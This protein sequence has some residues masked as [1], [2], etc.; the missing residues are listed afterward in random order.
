[1][2]EVPIV[3]CVPDYGKQKKLYSETANLAAMYRM[4]Y[5]GLDKKVY[6]LDG[7]LSK[8]NTIEINDNGESVF[9]D[10]KFSIPKDNDFGRYI[11]F[12]S[13]WFLEKPCYESSSDNPCPSDP[14]TPPSDFAAV[15]A[16][17]T[18]TYRVASPEDGVVYHWNVTGGTADKTVGNKI[19]VQ[20]QDTEGEGVVAV[21]G[22]DPETHCASET[23][24]YNIKIHKLPSSAFD[25][26]IV[27]NGQPLNI[28][29]SGDAPFEILYTI[30]GEER[31]IKTSEPSYQLPNVAG[32]YLITKI[33]DASCEAVPTVN[34][35]AE[36]AQKM[37]ALRIVEE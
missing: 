25:N 10:T 9:T 33:I 19:S 18:K 5:Y 31:S 26:A 21:Y 4:M 1:L 29:S 3:D 15:C 28:L 2:I 13:S 22:E 6:I 37:K 7:P 24:T 36:I 23:V 27:C 34:N 17:Q 11:D 20:W 30:D 16:S 14:E 12:V 35:A 32:R 8:I